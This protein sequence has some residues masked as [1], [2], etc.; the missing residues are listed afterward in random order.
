MGP[1]TCPPRE[2]ASASLPA[3]VERELDFIG[4]V[5]ASKHAPVHIKDPTPVHVAW[6][7]THPGE[8][9]PF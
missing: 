7:P 8:E 9:P 6:K 1:S 3:H 2:Q 5:R 4:V